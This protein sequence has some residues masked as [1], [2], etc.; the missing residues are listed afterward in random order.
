M[1][2]RLDAGLGIAALRGLA[3]QRLQVRGTAKALDK[4]IGLALTLAQ[5]TAAG[6]DQ[7]PAK[8]GRQQQ[9]EHDGFDQ[10]T[11]V[12]DQPPDGHVF[13]CGLHGEAPWWVPGG[14]CRATAAR[15]F[16]EKPMTG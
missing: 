13:Q 1:E 16:D 8:Y 2:H 11:G 5:H 3:V 10:Q 4:R 12:A 9:R 6:N 15:L 7:V 14:G